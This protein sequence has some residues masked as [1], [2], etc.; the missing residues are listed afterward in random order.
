[1]PRYMSG[2]N[3]RQGAAGTASGMSMLMGAANIVLKD[4]LSSWDN[5]VS[6]PVFEGFY[7][8]NMRYNPDQDIK[9][10]FN[11]DARGA[12][13][14]IAKEVRAQQLQQFLV[15][16]NN[17]DDRVLVN[18]KKAVREWANC[19]EMA[20]V[21][22]TDDEIEAQAKSPE[23]QQQA[24][25]MQMQQQLAMAELQGRGMKLMAEAE[26]AAAQ[27]REI[28]ESVRAMAEKAVSERVQAMYASVQ[29][30]Q[31]AMTAP[32]VAVAAD[33]IYRAAGGRDQQQLQ[34]EQS[35]AMGME[36]LENAV[37][38]QPQEAQPQEPGPQGAPGGTNTPQQ[39]QALPDQA[40][41]QMPMPSATEGAH[42]GVQTARNDGQPG[43]AQ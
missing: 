40:Q 42:A 8:W 41:A 6:Q 29:A 11:V 4:L 34:A 5:G 12:S 25:L 27:V 28:E 19:L 7:H 26:R 33:G 20:D 15:A 17:P 16:T 32:G 31:V 22:H 1:M 18:R 24:Q 38:P 36:F 30:A 13:S 10:D 35:Q 43:A 9:G 23:A 21:M 39:A 2:E 3:V 37:K 14:L